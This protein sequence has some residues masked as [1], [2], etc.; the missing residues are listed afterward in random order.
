MIDGKCTRA[1]AEQW[2]FIQ[3]YPKQYTTWIEATHAFEKIPENGAVTYGPCK[4]C[5]LTLE[6]C[7]VGGVQNARPVQE[8]T[9]CSA[10]EAEAAAQ[11]RRE[12]KEK[13]R[14]LGKA[15]R[16]PRT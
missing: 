13:H 6:Q 8:V 5:G 10:P 16:G 1:E 11:K 14:E 7:I 4:F 9:K 3:F 15:L 2:G 12:Y